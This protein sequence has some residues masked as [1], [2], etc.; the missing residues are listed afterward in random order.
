MVP[1]PKRSPTFI[2][3][4]EDAW[5]TSCCTEDQYMYLKLVR[6]MLCAAFIGAA[7]KATSSSMS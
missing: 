3:Q 4:P 6:Q 5:C 1:L 7:R 2:A